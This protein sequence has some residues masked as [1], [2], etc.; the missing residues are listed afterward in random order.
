[1][2]SS[3]V[4]N[5]DRAAAGRL[6]AG[7][8]RRAGAPLGGEAVIG[9]DVEG[10]LVLGEGREGDGANGCRNAKCMNGAWSFPSVCGHVNE[11]NVSMVGAHWGALAISNFLRQHDLVQVQWVT[12]SSGKLRNTPARHLTDRQSFPAVQAQPPQTSVAVVRR[13]CWSSLAAAPS[14]STCCASSMRR[15]GHLVGAD[16]GADQI[17]GGRAE[18]RA[19]HRRFRFARRIRI[20]GSGETRLMQIAEQETTDFEKALYSTRR[21]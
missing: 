16:G 1:M 6:K 9:V 7:L 3:A 14:M 18:A 10:G 5:F 19:D 2:A 17:V 4:M 12:L 8:Q 11:E 15:G 20:A 21:R 13:T